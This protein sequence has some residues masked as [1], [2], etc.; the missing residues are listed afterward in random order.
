MVA[1]ILC[2]LMFLVWLG[3]LA[4]KYYKL[5]Y[6]DWDLAFFAQAMWNLAHGSAYVSLFDTEFFANHANLI[7]FLLVPLYKIFGHP[8]TLLILKAVSFSAASY[9]LYLLAKEKLGESLGLCVLW[10]YWLYPANIYSL[11]YEFDFEN[12]APAFIMLAFY[13]YI[14]ENWTG[15]IINCIF[16]VLIKEN[17]PLIVA[18]F[19]I[20]G[21]I[22]KPDKACWGLIPTTLGVFC[23]VA[24]A[25]V[26][27]PL[28][29]KQTIGHHPYMAH[30]AQLVKAPWD[31]VSSIVTVK[32]VE[33]L[34]DLLAP[35]M[36]LPLLALDILFLV[37]PIVLQHLL[38]AV[39]QEHSIYYAYS[40]TIAPFLFLAFINALGFIKENLRPWVFYI[41]LLSAFVSSTAFFIVELGHIKPKFFDLPKDVPHC[42]ELI[43][44]VPPDAPV[45]AT[46]NF[47]PELSSRPY[48]YAFHK[49]YH[50]SYQNGP[51]HF[52]LPSDV[53]YALID[54]ENSWYKKY[55]SQ[56]PKFTKAH[57][58]RF[59]ASGWS[60]WKQYGPVVL[61]KRNP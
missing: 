28:M 18:A 60:V 10:F 15:F 56:H 39:G 33:W 27:V 53:R 49:I 8:M 24:L 12:L 25:F 55:S 20:H 29:G 22:T 19:G 61:Y 38:S 36:F 6:Y 21:W 42:W 3:L 35:L 23:F 51:N 54:F 13:F 41:F 46:F 11:I 47:L 32:K 57:V 7:A 48:L 34:K 58:E 45:V 2:L 43:K 37:F 14:H 59:L 17:M 52:Q 4:Y 44:M 5:N 50:S 1:K 30:Y 40:M 26:F 16:L 9:V 31:A